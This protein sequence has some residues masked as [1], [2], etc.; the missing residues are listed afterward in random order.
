MPVDPKLRQYRRLAIEWLPRTFDEAEHI[1]VLDE[2]LY[3]ESI[4]NSMMEL[5]LRILCSTWMRRLWTMAEGV[6]AVQNRIG[7]TLVGF[8]A[9][10]N[11]ETTRISFQF[12]GGSIHFS[13]LSQ[14]S[15]KSQLDV[16]D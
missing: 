6:R 10:E 4:H 12:L 5:G 14:M 1:L 15:A 8:L 3:M 16:R 7:K 11:Y 2:E 9:K 13:T